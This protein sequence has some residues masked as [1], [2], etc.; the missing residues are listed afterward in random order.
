VSIAVDRRQIS[1]P[2]RLAAKRPPQ[3][4]PEIYWLG[5]VGFVLLCLVA[6]A[7]GAA[8][9]APGLGFWYAA[10][11]KPSWTPP[12]AAFGPVWT[13]LYALMAIAAWR[14]W[15]QRRAKARRAA[16]TLFVMQLALNVAW[17]L[18]FFTMRMPGPAAIELGVLWC[19]VLATTV[20]FFPVS[21]IAALLMTPYLLWSTFAAFLNIAIW[22]LNG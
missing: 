20:V 7:V 11:H 22:R 12:A 10:L 18:V 1:A 4:T 3:S 13:V 16:L 5:L 17:P 6:A 14:V 21:R 19:A 8:F 9:T 2:K 15:L